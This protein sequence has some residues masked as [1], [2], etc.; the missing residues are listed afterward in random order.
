M[1]ARDEIGAAL[2]AGTLRLG[3]PNEQP[4]RCALC[5]VGKVWGHARTAVVHG[6]VVG[7]LCDTCQPQ[8]LK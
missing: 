7:W 5:G 6:V 2:R 3:R 8:E 4:V 1:P